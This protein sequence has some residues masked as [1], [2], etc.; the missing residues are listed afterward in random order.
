MREMRSRR[1]CEER[2]I[3]DEPEVDGTEF[4]EAEGEPDA[5]EEWE[6]K[7]GQ[8][9]DAQGEVEEDVNMIDRRLRT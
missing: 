6:D 2:E 4:E 7:L 9:E 8:A 1:K 3:L 5:E